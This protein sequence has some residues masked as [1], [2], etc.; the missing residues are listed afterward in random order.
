MP[1]R[2]VLFLSKGEAAPSTRY[3]ALAYLP[4]LTQAGWSAQHQ[5]APRG[6]KAWR[7]TLAAARQATVVVLLRRTL[8]G[9]GRLLLRRAASRLIFDFDDAIFL[10]DR[11]QPAGGRLRRFAA[12]ARRAD[13]IWAGNAYLAEAARA[14]NPQV[15]IMP[16]VMDLANYPA[17]QPA[18]DQPFT[19]VWVGSSATRRYLEELLPTLEQVAARVGRMHLKIIAD[20]TLTA[21]DARLQVEPIAWS[22]TTEG[23]ELATSHVGLAPLP[24]DPWTRGKCGCK[25]LQYMAARLPVVSSPVGVNRDFV[26]PEQTGLLA[27]TPEQWIAALLRL[28]ADAPLRVRMGQAGRQCVAEH[29]T[30][31][32]VAARMVSELE[33][34]AGGGSV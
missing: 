29:Y 11:G 17:A 19:V 34:L 7:S 27:T 21:G 4:L 15:S 25:V 23:L 30:Q 2:T 14:W 28:H 22:A 33:A 32:R 13:R 18:P 31:Q 1:A 9:A 3:R 26:I 24:D 16:T 6:W 10:N 5:A 20:F 12:L 8:H